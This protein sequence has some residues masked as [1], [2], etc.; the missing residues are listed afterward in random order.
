MDL[1]IWDKLKDIFNLNNTNDDFQNELDEALNS[2][3]IND[4]KLSLI[5][6]IEQN[7]KLITEFRDKIKLARFKILN[8][9]AKKTGEMY[10]IYSKTDTY[11]LSVCKEGKSHEIIKVDIKK[12]PVNADVDSVLRINN[13]KYILDEQATKYIKERTINIIEKILKEQ[14]E[15][16]AE[17]R[18]EGHIYEVTEKGTD[19]VWLYDKNADCGEIIEEIE[20]PL[21]LLDKIEETDT[22]KYENGKYVI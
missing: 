9:Y 3:N 8:E 22:V 12:I 2:E 14:A 17:K 10:F 11:N 6:K 16:L 20:F 18:I 7:N 19:R 1:D 4:D 5:E 13:G 21:E 15:Y